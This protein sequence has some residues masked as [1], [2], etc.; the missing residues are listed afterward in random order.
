MIV[1]PDLDDTQEVRRFI[2]IT[3]NMKD[4]PPENVGP[5]VAVWLVMLITGIRPGMLN[6]IVTANIAQ[7]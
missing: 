3:L 1:F 6:K 5:A 2:E 4:I 7:R